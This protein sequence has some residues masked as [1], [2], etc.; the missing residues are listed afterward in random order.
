VRYRLDAFDDPIE[1]PTRTPR[2]LE[3]APT[4]VRIPHFSRF[5]GTKVVDRPPAYLVPPRAAA[6]LARH[7]L[8]VRPAEGTLTLEV[9]RV[10]GIGTEGGRHILEAAQVGELEVDWRLER[11]AA[12]A[13][14]SLVDTDQPLGAIA[15]YLC[16]PESDDGAIENGMIDAP[17][18]GDD[19]PI[20][21]AMI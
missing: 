9:A 1:I 21:R 10:T 20:A 2:T 4:S 8:A 11:R 16:E 19:Y 12:P 6:H 3:G 18:R 15:V 14:W 17:A 5:V 13:G 7:G